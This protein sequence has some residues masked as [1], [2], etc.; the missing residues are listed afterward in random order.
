MS[1]G[2]GLISLIYTRNK[3]TKCFMLKL[4]ADKQKGAIFSEQTVNHRLL[5]QARVNAKKI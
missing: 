2:L 5:R 4:Y 1:L 3:L